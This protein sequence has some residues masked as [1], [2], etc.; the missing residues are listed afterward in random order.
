MTDAFDTLPEMLRLPQAVETLV[1]NGITDFETG[2]ADVIP[3][4]KENVLTVTWWRA[5]DVGRRIGLPDR[6]TRR[7][8]ADLFKA[9]CGMVR[10]TYRTWWL[11]ELAIVPFALMARTLKDKRRIWA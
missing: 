6:D 5:Q 3:F 10:K 8:C 2:N 7:I 1:Y 11:N 4:A 9:D